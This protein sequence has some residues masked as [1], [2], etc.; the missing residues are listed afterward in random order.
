[1]GGTEGGQYQLLG[2]VSVRV[3]KEMSGAEMDI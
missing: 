1:M 3:G 2:I